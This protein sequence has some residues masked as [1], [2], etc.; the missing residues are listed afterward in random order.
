MPTTT[1]SRV[2]V[3]AWLPAATQ[4]IPVG[5]LE[6]RGNDLWFRYGNRYLRRPDAVSLYGPLMPLGTEFIEPTAD[7]HMPAPLRDAAPDAWGRRVILNKLTGQRGAEADL[8]G[9][10]EATYLMASGSNRFGAVDFQASPDQYVP[11]EDDATL[12]QL[13]QA[14]ELVE[15]GEPLP[16]ALHA[17]FLSGTVM[18]GA[19]PKATIKHGNTHYLAKFTTS[20]D[21]F[22]SVGAEAA[23]IELAR[24]V[25]IDVPAFQ[26]A[27]V[28][29]KDVLL[30]ERFDRT[31]D[32]AR[33]MTVSALTI[34]GLGESEARYGTYPEILD[35]LR[36]VG[37][38]SPGLGRRLFERIA[39]NIAISNSDDHLRNHAA[40]WDGKQLSLTPAFDL[41]PVT[42]SGETAFQALAYGRD[43]Q[44]ESNFATLVE[45]AGIYDLTRP[46]ALNIVE[47]IRDTIEANWIEAA[48]KARL[49]KADRD[50]LW[51]NQ[52][53]NR[54]AF[55][56][57]PSVS[58]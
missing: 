29:G 13:L 28:L 2:F 19:R 8:D 39:F 26:M 12:D 54:A 52:F 14:A 46:Q 10:S 47:H 11:R 21:T 55:Y 37:D 5:V 43:G 38:G 1:S 49:R 23:S 9:L 51:H 35:Q 36:I 53:L 48:D 16:S 6:P 40:F 34:L 42:R 50:L 58:T 4:P 24:L 56:G 31:P 32:G 30:I 57:L 41:S 33:R 18:G 22:A 17:A 15:A 20:T 45:Q 3:W 7:L 27:K 25:G 44:R